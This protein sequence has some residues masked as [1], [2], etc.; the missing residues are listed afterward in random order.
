MERCSQIERLNIVKNGN[1]Q[2]VIYRF[3]AIPIKPAVTF[4]LQEENPILKFMWN[5]KGPQTGETILKNKV[6]R[7]TLPNFKMHCIA[8]IIKT[9]QCRHND[10]HLDQWTRIE[11]P[12]IS[13]HTHSFY[14]GAKTIQWGKESYQEMM[15]NWIST[16]K[17][18]TPTP[19]I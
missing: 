17:G 6:R 5:L 3:K 1:V 4:F 18:W 11:G 10:R 7:L 9:A 19:C 2:S 14:T 16:C 8:T 15:K 12:E 13:P